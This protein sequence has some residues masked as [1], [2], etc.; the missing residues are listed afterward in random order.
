[1]PYCSAITGDVWR[2]YKWWCRQNNEREYSKPKFL[3]HISTKMPR[4]VRW[5]RLPHS[6]NPDKAYQNPIFR[7]PDVR[8]PDGVAE[9]DFTGSQVIDFRDAVN[10][11][12][13]RDDM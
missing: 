13:G 4:A 1:M 8:A 3:Q 9:M 6:P 5:W 7:R 11:L 12:V 2:L 10:E